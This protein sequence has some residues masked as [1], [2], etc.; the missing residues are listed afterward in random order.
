ME[1]YDFQF[2]MVFSFLPEMSK[3]YFF[4]FNMATTLAVGPK[5]GICCGKKTCWSLSDRTADIE[6]AL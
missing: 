4:S 1:V 2:E 3:R 6:F 5:R